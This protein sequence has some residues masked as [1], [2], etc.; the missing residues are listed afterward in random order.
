MSDAMNDISNRSMNAFKWS[1]I[2][3]IL[4]KLISP[5][6]NMLLARIL[7]PEAFGVLATV[8]MVISFAELFVESGFQKFLIQHI[9]D[10]KQQEH[11][12]MSVAFWAN[13]AFSAVIWILV[14]L[15]CKPLATFAGD[16]TLG[17]VIAISGGMIPIYSIV[18]IQDCQIKKNLDFKR[19]FYVRIIS[20]LVPLVVTLPLACLG[21]GFWSLIIGNIA[22]LLI[23]TITLAIIG[24]FKPDIYFDFLKLKHML[25][26]GAVTLLDGIAIWATNWIDSLLISHLMSDYYLGLYRNSVSTITALFSIITASITPVLFS[27]LSKLQND[28]KEFNQLF[29]NVQKVLC[30]ILLPLGVGIFFYRDF[31]TDILFGAQWSEA[32]DIVGILALT[33]ALRT[34]FISFYGDAY[35]AKGRFYLPLVL[36]LIDLLF[37]VP[38]CIISVKYGFW[39]LVYV[40]AFVKLDLMIPEIIIVWFVCGITPKMTAKAMSHAIISTLTM[41]IEI[42][43]LQNLFDSILWKITSIFISIVVYFGILFLF[44]TEREQFLKP[45]LKKFRKCNKRT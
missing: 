6:I 26:V 25:K 10:S 42:K 7:A 11:Q 36:Q 16:P 40:R 24:R 8:T 21:L 28:S 14:I 34:V 12:Y 43:L 19:L 15:F 37:L 20:S 31:V 30:T 32:A 39:S 33:T 1:S 2:T 29:L 13:L 17:Y 44:S 4:S 9:F 45:I 3:E 41:V 35:R 38:A 23:R 22:G 5:I 27:A 18:G